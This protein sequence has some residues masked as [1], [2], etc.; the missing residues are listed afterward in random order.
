MIRRSAARQ[1]AR[2]LAALVLA[3][4]AP[5]AAAQTDELVIAMAAPIS[6]LDP[7]FHNLTPNSGIA[8]HVFENLT[9]TDASQN[10]KPGLA[11]SWRTLDELTA[12]LPVVEHPHVG[13]YHLTPS[14]TR[15]S[16]TPT[17]LRRHAPRLGEHGREV[18]AEVGLSEEEIH[19][20]I[21]AGVLRLAVSRDD[22]SP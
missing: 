1:L 4:T 17:S 5:W 22:P 10:L 7:H 19:A 11:E 8:K 12:E 6:S 18:L 20:L 21:D 15:F 13:R 14:P 16:A 2:A 9:A 3:A